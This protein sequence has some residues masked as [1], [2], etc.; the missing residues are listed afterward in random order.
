MANQFKNLRQ[1]EDELNPL[2]TVAE[3]EKAGIAGHSAI[4][5]YE[6]GDSKPGYDAIKAYK[7][8]FK[9]SYEYLFNEVPF[10]LERHKYITDKSLL[11]K[12]NPTSVDNLNK[13]LTDTNYATFN[14]YMLNA[15]LTNPAELQ[16]IMEI[17]FRSM[18]QL[19]QIYTDSSLRQ[20]EKE[21]KAASFWYSLNQNMN[22]YFKS[23]LMSNLEPGYKKYEAK[24]EEL[25]ISAEKRD[26]EEGE[27]VQK[28]YEKLLKEQEERDIKITITEKESIPNT[29]ENKEKE[30]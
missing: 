23:T 11:S 15:F 27:R 4:Y 28:L 22:F 16:N 19:N 6:S 30:E 3:L 25:R 20:G 13:L 26:K 2:Y 29:T 9:C 24:N 18:Y 17:I 7:K 5:K 21:L 8:F 14:T 1:P 10:P 12:L